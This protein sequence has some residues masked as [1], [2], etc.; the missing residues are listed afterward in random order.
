MQ[1]FLP[2][3]KADEEFSFNNSLFILG[4]FSPIGDEVMNLHSLKILCR[5][6]RLVCW[7][8]SDWR[9]M[10]PD[11]FILLPCNLGSAYDRTSHHIRGHVFLIGLIQV[12]RIEIF[13]EMSTVY[14]ELFIFLSRSLCNSFG[15]FQWFGLLCNDNL[16]IASCCKGYTR[17]SWTTRNLIFFGWFCALCTAVRPWEKLVIANE[18][19]LFSRPGTTPQG[20]GFLRGIH[21]TSQSWSS[22]AAGAGLVNDLF[23]LFFLTCHTTAA[24]IALAHCGRASVWPC[25]LLF[26]SFSL[27]P[28]SFFPLSPPTSRSP[29]SPPITPHHLACV[30]PGHTTQRQL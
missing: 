8:L 29:P 27:L 13:K 10:N 15:E 16:L 30:G 12:W 9:R 14:G 11:I 5:F 25:R 23:F 6:S 22:V 28:P 20:R 26:L 21:Q 1:E 17:R 19:R 7:P 2:S 3:L 24:T 18:V 4:D